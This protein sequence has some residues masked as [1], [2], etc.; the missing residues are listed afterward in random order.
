VIGYGR[1]YGRNNPI[2]AERNEKHR[3][4]ALRVLI[5]GLNDQISDLI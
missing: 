4:A 3:K 5:T 1:T 2:T